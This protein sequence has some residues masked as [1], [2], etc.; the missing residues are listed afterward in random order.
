[1]KLKGKLFLYGMLC[2]FIIA[3]A[4]MQTGTK[5]SAVEVNKKILNTLENPIW[6]SNQGLSKGTGHDR[7]DLGVVLPKDGFIEVRQTN[8]DYK[9]NITVE[10]L[11]DDRNTETSVSVGDNWVT[12]TASVPSVPFVKT[13][14]TAE[15]PVIEYRVS[16]SAKELPSFKPKDDEQAFFAKWE[17]SKASFA[18]V[19]N[20]YIQILVPIL[21]QAY[22]KKMSDFKSID[23]L[24]A[25]YDTMFETYNKLEGL[26]FTPDKAT[27]KNIPNRYF[28][29][30]DKHGVGAAY[31][32]GS[33][34]AQTAGSVAGFWLQPTWGGLHEIGH[35]YQGAFM[36]D[37]SFSTSEVWNNLYADSM[38]K[39]MLGAKYYDGWLYSTD[40]RKMEDAFNRLVYEEKRAV[41]D[42]SLKEKLYALVMMK[43]KAGDDAFTHFNQSY[44]TAKNEGTPQSSYL[45]DL[46]NKYYGEASHYD[47]AAYSE[48]IHGPMSREQ[49][50]ANLYSGNKAVYPLAAL[51]SGTNLKE[52]RKKIELDT[53]WG[54]VD[55]TQLQ[56]FNM[57]ANATI[58]FNMDDFNQIKGK[59]LQIKD[60]N[61]VIR[62]LKISTPTIVVKNLP[63]GIYS[64]NIPTGQSELYEP[65][66]NYLPVSDGKN[67]QTI[68]MK[69]LKSSAVSIQKMQFTGLSYTYATANIDTEAGTFELNSILSS[70]HVYFGSSE[71]ASVEILDEKGNSIFKQVMTGSGSP[72][73]VFTA[74][75]K[76][77]YL[78]KLRLAEPSR[79]SMTGNSKAMTNKD[80]NQT[81]E[82]TK[83]GL[84]NLAMGVD[85]KDALAEYK[86]KLI[87]FANQ[88][89]KNPIVSKEA[90][91]NSIT[92]LKK[93]LSYLDTPDRTA[94]EQRY[95][96]LIAENNLAEDIITGEKIKFQM[97]GLGDR[98]FASL[99]LDLDNE[100]A[101]A[102][103]VAGKPHNYFPDSY[104]FIKIY[105]QRG[106]EV[107][108]TDY[109]GNT[110][111]PERK[112]D[113]SIKTG[114]FITVMHQEAASRLII[115]NEETDERYP[116]S[117]QVT[118]VV[119]K[120]GLKKV[121][122]SAI[123]GIDANEMDG[124]IF[125]FDIFG[126]SYLNLANVT[127]D[128]PKNVVTV[129]QLDQ[130]AYWDFKD[131][132]ASV[133]I[134]NRAG[135]QL[136][137]QALN[138]DNR[139]ISKD[140]SIAEGYYITLTHQEYEHYLTIMNKD[141]KQIYAASET[142]TYR[143]T[144]DG[145][146][147][148]VSVPVPDPNLLE[149]Q[150]FSFEMLGLG[151]WN[152]ANITVNLQKEELELS[153]LSG[154]PHAYFGSENPYVTLQVRD[155]DGIEIYNHSIIGNV[156]VGAVTSKANLKVG[157]YILIKHAEAPSR[158]KYSV[159]N[160]Q[161]MDRLPVQNAF[162]VTAN[163]LV[164]VAMDD[165]PT[166]DGSII[167]GKMFTFNFTGGANQVF[168][169]VKLDLAN[170]SIQVATK[171][172]KPNVDFVSDYATITIY[173]EKGNMVYMKNY[174]GSEQYN[175]KEVTALLNTGFYVKVTHQE[176]QERLALNTGAIVLPVGQ[177]QIY[178]VLDNGLKLVTEKDI[179]VLSRFD[180]AMI[181]SQKLNVTF[182]GLSDY[183]FATMVLDK[184]T[185]NLHIETRAIRPHSYFSDAY[186][187][188]EVRNTNDQVV[189]A[190]SFI[191]NEVGKAEVVDVTILDGYTLA[192][193]HRENGR[194]F[195]VDS[196]SDF[197]YT[198]QTTSV[199]N[200]IPTG[201]KA[202]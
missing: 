137:S 173:D 33:Y 37:S 198:M 20:D 149:G 16:E 41:S 75:I 69:V 4:M 101:T 52:A 48:L 84:T 13:N 146:V 127:V 176:G 158:L 181:Y 80:V 142:N 190:K 165:V 9:G 5:V 12:L 147:K 129:K 34:T 94:L 109:L 125:T 106:K 123:P 78:I 30:A 29:K 87:A 74:N 180:K 62:E 145:L 79:F 178:R 126:P 156:N 10:L 15:K 63:V 83:Y 42:W 118:Y 96:D 122:V 112:T 167:A 196:S 38:Q 185:N 19:G 67:D 113:V 102:A 107:L 110:S 169:N 98:N 144:A 154:K 58:T 61:A 200:V 141:T 23:K 195:V 160:E 57:K 43:D 179:P 22:L 46:L 14:F 72:V 188:I 161:Q 140:V 35:G 1:M 88:I 151:N 44:R 3:I 60:G 6:M 50:E 166:A 59:G 155:K 136:Y 100:T 86:E 8:P 65:S 39:K 93:M 111:I 56:T 45:F 199:F 97:K 117:K 11:N 120:D 138:G 17:S 95:K 186:A 116:A 119:T 85:A 92:R 177:A 159:E 108:A 124:S 121:D 174:N 189:Y 55:N 194:L 183:Q 150:N 71:Y 128:I 64:L 157:D 135:K 133:K 91:A 28:A 31:Y 103:N 114:Y 115:T 81:F 134:Y 197:R 130:E 193:M 26:S 175:D 99:V 68:N 131:D 51:L 202:E 53:K 162:L 77:G 168:T 171:A 132:Y 170:K 70:P 89:E 152:F 18:L 25:Y 148:V 32:G 105:N 7:Q 90:N 27:D 163:G 143:V 40:V 164:K 187:S 21:D 172:G 76:T 36:S 47:F 191:G 153:Q 49:K 184:A 54:L 24:L 201:L 73:G 2:L 104:A 139:T 82:V 182:K 66:T 192:I